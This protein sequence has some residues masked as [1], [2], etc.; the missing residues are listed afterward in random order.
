MKPGATASPAASTIA[1]RRRAV[2]AP[3]R[4]MRS[5]RMPTSAATARRAGA[6][7][8]GPAADDGEAGRFVRGSENGQGRDGEGQKRLHDR[9]FRAQAT[10]TC[11]VIRWGTAPGGC[12]FT[13]SGS[14]EKVLPAL[15]SGLMA[16]VALHANPLDVLLR[17]LDAD[18]DQAGEK[19]ELLRRK[20][21]KLLAW[22][23]GA[24]PYALVDETLDRVM[25]RLSE[26]DRPYVSDPSHYVFG[27]A[28]NVIRE[29][30]RRDSRTVPPVI[31]FPSSGEETRT[32]EARAACLDLCL[33]RLGPGNRELLLA[34]YARAGRQRIAARRALAEGLAIK[35]PALRL[36]LHR[37]RLGLETCVRVA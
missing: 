4:A 34:Y 36:R 22:Q 3:T 24:D 17:L 16:D 32:V 11:H 19:Y 10:G 35:G 29:S 14:S 33:Q 25:R 2:E 6:V 30:W 21:V 31:T 37:I 8:D 5:P 26:G 20:L 1:L 15:P 23:G 27:F 18:R 7:V 13:R 9:S 28:R 12:A